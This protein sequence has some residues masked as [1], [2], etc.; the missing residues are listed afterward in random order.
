MTSTPLPGDELRDRTLGGRYRMVRV[1]GKGGMG[2]VWTARDQ[3]AGVDVAVKVVKASLLDDQA[4]L[5]RFRR[6]MRVMAG[7]LHD[8]IVRGLDA[9][10]DAG[11]LWLAMELLHGQT[12]RERLDARGRLSWQESLGVVR[13]IASGLGAAH[14][15][16]V[17]HRDLKPENVMIVS[18]DDGAMHVKLLDFGVAKATMAGGAE[19]SMT[20]TGFIV[21]TPG[22]V[23]PEV[24]LEGK[25]ND[26]R[27][28]FY[29]LGVI[30]YEMGTGQ[31]P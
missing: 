6:E 19:S 23:A 20:G 8:N 15:A 12:L 14:A 4:A 18:S 11:V 7:L 3:Q 27:T 26:P 31:N 21:G 5:T 25:T 16:G 29:A 10:E 2:A 22:Y 13:Q 9:G 1:L 24:V 28:D 30:L 17:V